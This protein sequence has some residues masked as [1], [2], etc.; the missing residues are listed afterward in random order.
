[1]FE[2]TSVVPVLTIMPRPQVLLKPRKIASIK[3][4]RVFF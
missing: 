1:M 4:H 3:G 2:T